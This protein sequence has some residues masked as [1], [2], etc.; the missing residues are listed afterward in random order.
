MMAQ[1]ASNGVAQ[2][3]LLEPMAFEAGT[4]HAGLVTEYAAELAAAGF[5]LE[6]FGSGTWLVRTVPAVFGRSDPRRALEDVLEGI[7]EGRDLVGDTREAALTA[8][9]CKRAAIKGG[10]VLSTE[11]MRQL[12]RQLEGCQNPGSCPHGRPTMLV[13]STDQLEREFGRRGALA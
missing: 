4:V 10:Q 2:Q 1:Q 5:Q 6:P 12:L 7:E 11:E 13:L 9:I 3:A 8:V